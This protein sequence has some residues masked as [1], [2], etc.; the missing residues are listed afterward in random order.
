MAKKLHLVHVKSH[1]LDK[2]PSAS[3]INYG[4][5]AVNYNADSPAL[6]IRDDEDN[7]V[8]FIAEPYFE[9]IVGTGVTENDGETFTPLSEIIQQDEETI[10][11]AFNDINERKA[12]KDYVDSAVSAA[13]I[14]V[15]SE[16]NSASTNPV[17]NRAIYDEFVTC[18]P[19]MFYGTCS[20]PAG[21][22][23]KDVVCSAFTA[24]DLTKGVLIFV[25]FDNTN[26]YG[27]GITMSVN[28]TTNSDIRKSRATTATTVQNLSVAQE[29]KGNE[30]YLFQFDGTYWVLMTTEYDTNTTYTLSNLIEG[31]GNYVADSNVYRYQL[32]FQRA[33]SDSNKLTPLNNNSNVT[34]NTQ[35]MLTGATFDPFGK[36]FY[37]ATTTAVNTGADVTGTSLTFHYS[38]INLRYTF[39]S[40]SLTAKKPVYLTVAP[41]SDGTVKI[42]SATPLVQ[43][44]PT[45]NTG[46]WYILLGRAASAY[47]MTL[48]SEHPVY[49]HNGTEIVELLN[50]EIMAGLRNEFNVTVD[51]SLDSA[52]TNPVENRVIYEALCNDEEVMAAALNDLN[53]RK[54]DKSYVDDAVSS[55]TID[56]DTTLDSASTNPVENRA[57]WNVFYENEMVT[58]AALNNLNDTKADKSYVDAAIS[59]STVQ[60]DSQLDSASTNPVE[61]RVITQ[62]LDENELIVASALNFLNNEI[63]DVNNTIYEHTG[64]TIPD[65]VYTSSQMHLPEVT[66]DDN[67]KTLRVVNGEWALVS[68]TN[69]YSGS[70]EPSQSL[71]EE[72]DIYLQT[73]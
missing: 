61:N 58:S 45:E 1:V 35:T 2:A 56:V 53:E 34:V 67:G 20:T 43:D 21:T 66:A 29:I 70:G 12:D 30:T 55:I 47:Q 59:A 17:E 51:T 64:T 24:A 10:A 71:G 50:P 52:S 40:L 72:G 68:E 6:Y 8:K 3:T 57:I 42:A 41:Q 18:R 39:N 36:I 9:K 14:T 54:A 73:S 62:Q 33:G 37:Y 23:K 15:D 38:N 4:E 25:T 7:I 26:T 48:Y 28:G 16:I 5:I 31:T 69:V 49:M 11:A 13:T 19:R 22:Q 63:S 44:L 65:T 32:L 46:Y 27:T 60:V